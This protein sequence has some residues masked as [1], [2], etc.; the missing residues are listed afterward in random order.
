MMPYLRMMISVSTPGSSMSPSTSTTRPSALRVGVGQCVISADDHVA[1]LGVLRS[2]LRDLHVHDQP[3]I[4]RHDEARARL[5]DVEAADDRLRPA[6][7][8]PDD[9]PFGAVLVGPLLDA[10]DD[11]VAVHRLIQ[12]AAGD[13]DVARHPLDRPSGTTKPNPRGWVVIRPTTRFMRSGRP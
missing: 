7:E 13:V 4:E 8:D 12:V 11:A 2:S 6:L 10:R 1:R 9:A 5:V 3:A